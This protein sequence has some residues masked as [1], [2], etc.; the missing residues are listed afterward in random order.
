MGWVAEQLWLHVEATVVDESASG[1]KS[2]ELVR[3]AMTLTV[4]NVRQEG[5]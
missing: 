2:L 1:I 4:Q 3:E 5:I